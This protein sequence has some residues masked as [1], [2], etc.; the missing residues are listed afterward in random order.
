MDEITLDIL[1]P[2]LFVGFYNQYQG[3]GLAETE[4]L[5][6]KIKLVK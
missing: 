4:P 3:R 5:K 1:K 2:E 6:N